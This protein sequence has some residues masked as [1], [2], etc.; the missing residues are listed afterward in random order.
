MV[1]ELP[2]GKTIIDAYADFM[3][4]LFESTKEQFETSELDGK[5][6]PSWRTASKNFELILTHPNGWGG[7]Q[8]AQ[9]RAAAVKAGI[10]PDNRAGHSRVQFVTDGEASFSFCATRTQAGGSLK[11]SFSIPP[12]TGLLTSSKSGEK[13]L[14]IDAGGGTIDISTYKVLSDSPLRVEEL[15]ESKCE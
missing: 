4:Y 10:V 9:L 15:Y 2:R 12:R 8:Q 3:G 5:R 6:K 7:L 11:V 13:V 14:I 1:P